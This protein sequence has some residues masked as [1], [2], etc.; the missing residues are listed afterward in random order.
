MILRP[1]PVAA[2]LDELRRPD[3]TVIL[4]DPVGEVFTQ[5]RASDLSGRSHLV[6][7]CPRYEGVT[8][9]SGRSSTWSSRSATTS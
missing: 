6:F 9:G 5:S 7:V 4:L 3:S 2:A 8:N 1:E